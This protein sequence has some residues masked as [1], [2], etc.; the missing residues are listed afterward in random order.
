ML[1]DAFDPSGDGLISPAEY[2]AFLSLDGVDAAHAD[3]D[4]PGNR[5]F[6]SY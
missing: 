6:G 5:P 2:R 4:A 1:L 3:E